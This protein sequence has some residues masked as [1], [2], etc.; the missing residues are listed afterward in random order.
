MKISIITPIYNGALLIERCLD[1]VFTQYGNFNLDVIVI[2]DGSTDN[3]LEIVQQ[4]PKPITILQQHN[5]GPAA[6]RNVGIGAATGKYLAFLD[7]DDY[8]EPG[9]LEQTVA[10]LE[11]HKEA[12]AVSVGQV[13]KIL[14]K[15]ERVMPQLLSTAN[16]I[17]EEGMVLKDFYAFWASHNHVCTGSVLMRTD[18]VKQTGGQR[19]ELRI[20]EDFEFWTY[21][22]TFGKWGFIPKVL[23]VSD[24]GAVTKAQGWWTKNKKRWAS[25]PTV[26]QW[27]RRIVQRLPDTLQ[28]TFNAAKGRIAKNLAY[29]MIMSNR[30]VEALKIVRDYGKFFPKDKVSN[31]LINSSKS[32]LLWIPVINLLY[33]RE[34]LRQLTL[35]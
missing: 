8:W 19:P 32:S 4:Y 12:V 13:H 35:G 31:I 33:Y 3:S 15:S 34:Y 28:A 9:F 11:T 29:A 7:A 6:A 14:G 24:G 20:T 22:A 30:N 18:I 23:F 16:T 27:E 21:L 5:Q 2:D 17:S 10:F 1:S 26:A 25:A